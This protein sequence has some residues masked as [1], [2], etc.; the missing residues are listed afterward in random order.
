MSGIITGGFGS[1]D[2]ALG[3]CPEQVFGGDQFKLFKLVKKVFKRM[4]KHT[5]ASIEY[6][7]KYP[8]AD[9]DAQAKLIKK[10]REDLLHLKYTYKYLKEK[11]V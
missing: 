1:F 9:V 8:L 11:L 7:I 10:L 3:M 2:A 6:S 4:V 5:K